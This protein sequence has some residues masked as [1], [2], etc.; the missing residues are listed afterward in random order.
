MAQEKKE[1]TNKITEILMERNGASIKELSAELA[2]SEMTVRRD[3]KE[4]SLVDT[5]SLVHGAAIYKAP[6]NRS[7]Y[8]LDAAHRQ[9]TAEK[10]RIG[11][12]AAGL[13]ESGDTVIIDV[14]TTTEFLARHLIEDKSVTVLCFTMNSLR[15]LHSKNL[16]ALI[17]GGGYYHAD[18]QLFESKETIDLIR[19]TRAGKLFLS[20]AGVS[21]ELGITCANQYEVPIKQACLDSSLKKILLADS[22]KFGLIHPAYFAS[23]EQIDTIITDAG[24]SPEWV[25]DLESRG[26]TVTV[27]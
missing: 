25:C 11:K 1:R 12:A 22:A 16:N 24:I 7:H 21:S 15:Y 8:Q 3:L 26:I 14:G 4:L 23:L 9:N 5:V 2:V 20:A 18:T 6:E 19:R 17:F 13:V 27:V 10:E